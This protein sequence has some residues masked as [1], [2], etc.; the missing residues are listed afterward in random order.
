MWKLVKN[1]VF[2]GGLG[3]SCWGKIGVMW[4]LGV[5]VCGKGGKMLIN[6][7]IVEFGKL[8]VYFK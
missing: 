3:F 2:I 4:V 6:E 1:V 8:M 7:W 5:V